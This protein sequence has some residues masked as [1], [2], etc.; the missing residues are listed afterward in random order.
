MTET[1][2]VSEVDPPMIVRLASLAT[3]DP[4]RVRT[5]GYKLVFKRPID[6]AKAKK[7]L[8]QIEADDD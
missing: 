2:L 3:V 5:H 6:E 8:T 1:S 4:G 7:R